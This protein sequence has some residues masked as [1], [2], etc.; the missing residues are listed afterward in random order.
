MLR[1]ACLGLCLATAAPVYAA[2]PEADAAMLLERA[3]V[4]AVKLDYSGV[5]VLQRGGE[6]SSRRVTH[7][8]N[9]KP[10][11][12]KIESLDGPPSETL[13]RGG[14][15]VTYLPHL[16][17]VRVEA[18]GTLPGFP[19]IVHVGREQIE[20]HYVVRRFDA[21]RVAGRAAIA[22]ALDPRDR[23]H[24]G[25]RFWA[26]RETGLML[27]MQTIS[28]RGEVVEQIAFTQ[29]KTGGIAPAL[30]KSNMADTRGWRVERDGSA[31]L[32]L[33]AWR[34]RWVPEGFVRTGTFRRTLTAASGSR[35]D[36]SQLLYSDGLAALSVFIEPWSPERSGSPLQLGALNMVGKRHGKFWL[37]IVGEA[38]MAAIRKVADSIEF[39]ETSPR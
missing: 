20:R 36:V 37:T 3:R 11:Q 18:S 22:V 24:Y 27:R 38:P 28:E 1:V 15:V 26:D 4:A 19:G 9:G 8:H 10:V 31:A 32:D 6:V 39:A 21:E 35:R 33:P 30:L 2:V 12:E 34:V 14:E 5:F 23:W 7:L 29:L 16:K 17:L 13:R 25:Y